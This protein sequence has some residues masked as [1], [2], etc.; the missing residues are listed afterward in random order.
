MVVLPSIHMNGTSKDALL[1]QYK[2]C[3]YAVQ[4]AVDELQTNPPHSRDYYPQ[5]VNG[6]DLYASY[7]PA[8]DQHNEWVAK[9]IEV[10]N[11]LE[12]LIVGIINGG[13]KK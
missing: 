5:N 13:F 1:K 12:T 8:R 7:Y 3:Y 9:L 10:K 11:D 6:D 2:D 4:K